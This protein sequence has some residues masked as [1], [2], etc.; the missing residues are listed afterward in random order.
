MKNRTLFFIALT[1]AFSF[2]SFAQS[3]KAFLDNASNDLA[4]VSYH[5]EERI[6]MNF[7]SSI[8]T[9]DVP[10]LSMISRK[11]LG[12]NNVRIVTPKYAKVRAKILAIDVKKDYEPKALSI[13][14]ITSQPINTDKIVLSKATR[15]RVN[16]DVI[17][18][19]ERVVDKGYKS[20]V[21]ITKVADRHFFEGDLVLAAKWYNELFE[22]N[23]TDL[24]A[25]YYY[26]YAESLKAVGQTTKSNEMMKIFESKN[27]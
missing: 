5:V 13:T 17:G 16:I 18:T 23:P 15:D 22:A 9:Y 7:G 27:L 14:D 24:Q 19:Y 6:N 11:D 25:I 26:R 2:H 12:E 10:D 21:M 3:D 4:V 20:V 1:G 8:T